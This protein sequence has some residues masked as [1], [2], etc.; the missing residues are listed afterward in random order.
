MLFASPISSPGNW[1]HRLILSVGRSETQDYWRRNYNQTT[2]SAPATAVLKRALLSTARGSGG[3]ISWRTMGEEEC[4]RDRLTR[5]IPDRTPAG[6]ER[7]VGV[8]VDERRRPAGAAQPEPPGGTRRHLPATGDFLTAKNTQKRPQALKEPTTRQDLPSL[9]RHDFK[10][11]VRRAGNRV[12][13]K[14]RTQGQT[15]GCWQRQD[16][17]QKPSRKPQ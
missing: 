7:A 12:Q 10:A 13:A 8:D 16:R 1:K 15:A 14:R 4:L 2:T 11:G 9:I 17:K 5:T 3:N 6:R